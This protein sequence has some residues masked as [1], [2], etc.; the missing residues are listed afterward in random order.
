MSKL[1]AKRIVVAGKHKHVYL[2][3]VLEIFIFTVPCHI[4]HDWRVLESTIG[5]S[6]RVLLEGLGEYYLRVSGS[7]LEHYWRIIMTTIE[8]TSLIDMLTDMSSK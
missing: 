5:G 8:G 3:Y 2:D 4:D 6:W 7:I 1:T